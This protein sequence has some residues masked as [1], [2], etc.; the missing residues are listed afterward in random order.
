MTWPT[1]AQ[2]RPLAMIGQMPRHLMH[3]RQIDRLERQIVP[4]QIERRRPQ[5]DSAATHRFS[6]HRRR[7]IVEAGEHLRVLRRRHA[8]I[9]VETRAE[10]SPLRGARNGSNTAWPYLEPAERRRRRARSIDRCRPASLAA[11]RRGVGRPRGLRTEDD[12]QAAAVLDEP[13]SRAASASVGLASL[14]MTTRARA[15]TSSTRSSSDRVATS[16]FG[17]LA[18]RQGAREIERGSRP[19]RR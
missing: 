13:R 6:E 14:T 17:A 2:L 1:V 15:S 4:E 7:A 16:N 3:E 10:K 9:A 12:E 19:A 8:A 11:A 18:D 5:Q